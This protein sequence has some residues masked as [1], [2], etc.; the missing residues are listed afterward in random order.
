MLSSVNN[1]EHRLFERSV[2][3]EWVIRPFIYCWTFRRWETMKGWCR[4][5]FG[6]F[7]AWFKEGLSGIS[8]DVHPNLAFGGP[9]I[10]LNR[11]VN[12][13]KRWEIKRHHCIWMKTVVH[14][15]IIWKWDSINVRLYWIGL[16]FKSLK[17]FEIYLQI[18]PKQPTFF[19]QGH[20]R[21]PL[22]LGMVFGGALECP[23]V[24]MVIELERSIHLGKGS[25]PWS[26]AFP[27]GT[28]DLSWPWE[29]FG[30]VPY[31][32]RSPYSHWH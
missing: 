7:L 25:N 3:K 14:V 10:P 28:A 2:T 9:R 29:T 11:L 24:S 6:E 20:H 19:V 23:Y 18:L 8:V 31:S 22:N 5:G 15:I 26:C 4:R 30:S 16:K 1:L 13:W 32:F 17:H 12:V 27:Q 21:P